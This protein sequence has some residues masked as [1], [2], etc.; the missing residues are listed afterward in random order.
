MVMVKVK[1]NDDDDYYREYPI[2][3]LKL[4]SGGSNLPCV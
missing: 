4:R 3:V 1:F 2:E